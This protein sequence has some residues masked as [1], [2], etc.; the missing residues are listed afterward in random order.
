MDIL[1]VVGTGSTW[2]DNELKYSLRSIEKNGINVE[3]VFIGGYIPEFVNKENVIC[4]PVAD[5]TN[6][7]HYNILNVIEEVIDSTDIG[8]TQSGNFLYSS[9]DHFYIKPVDFNS[10]PIYSRGVELPKEVKQF[11]LHKKYHTTLVSTR[12]LLEEYNLPYE[13]FAWHGNTHFNTKLWNDPIMKELRKKSY[14]MPEG[15]EP[16]CLMLN[17]QMSVDPFEPVIRKDKKIR[18]IDKLAMFNQKI[19]DR[20]CCSSSPNIQK[21]YLATFL[22]NNLPE[23]SKYEL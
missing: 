22:E 23:K 4:V 15:C 12:K 11:D 5:K 21:S 18:S 7:K 17:Y 3:R 6:V 19:Q 16:T 13:H 8:C 10:Y 2:N 20:E 14:T 9:D 1:Y